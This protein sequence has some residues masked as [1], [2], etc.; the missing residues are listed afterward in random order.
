VKSV[1]A[2]RVCGVSLTNR[3]FGGPVV[4][5]PSAAR[6]IPPGVAP[7]DWGLLSD[8]TARAVTVVLFSLMTLRFAE[9]YLATGRITGLMLVVSELLV[10]IM[11]LF[12]RHATSV[13]RGLRA[14]ALSVLSLAGPPLARPAVAMAL[15]PQFLSAAV[16]VI[17]LLVVIGG[18]LS[19]GRS[20]GL[21]PA[22]RGIVSTGL[23]RLVRHPIYMGYLVTHVAFVAA[24][25]SPWNV[26]LFVVAD[27]AL[28]AR[29]VCEEATL[30]RDPAYRAY[31]RQVRWRVC[32]GVF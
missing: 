19:L 29:A 6:T 22:N 16:A 18:K 21:M 7:I 30:A 20:F 4:V 10:V 17:G 8:L 27:T 5:T 26:V 15:V 23:Y 3:A 31:Q 11:T 28:V 25:P 1:P 32:P 2:L 24:N 13:D 12:R 14:R 9:D